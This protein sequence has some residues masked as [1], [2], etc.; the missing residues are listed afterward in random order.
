MSDDLPTRHD[1]FSTRAI[2]AAT[3]PPDVRQ[4]PNA[5]PIYQS[6]TFSADDAA[7][8]G[9]I[10]SDRVPGYAYARIDHPTGA[11]M[12]AAIAEI[13]GAEAGYPFASGM[14]AIHAALLASLSAGDHVVATR[15]IY[16]SSQTLL[17]R[18]FGRLGVE[19]VLR[20]P[21]GPR[22]GRRR[23]HRPDAGALP[24]DHLQPDDRRRRPVPAWSR[25]AHERGVAR[26]RRQHVRLAVPLPAAELGAD[27]VVG[28]VHEVARR[29]LATSSPE[30]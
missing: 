19:I 3:R 27:L 15:A 29:P 21:H 24:R 7:E 11:A 6:A 1:G 18:V 2:R 9:D 16:G 4:Q 28:V 26:H 20:R 12:A 14:A 25:L 5:V 10:L 22:C 13:E 30:P 8:L 17:T 23:L